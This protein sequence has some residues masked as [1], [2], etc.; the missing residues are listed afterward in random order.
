MSR[1]GRFSSSLHREDANYKMQ[2]VYY[3]ESIR[4]PYF[5]SFILSFSFSHREPNCDSNHVIKQLDFY[6]RTEIQQE[7]AR[8]KFCFEISANTGRLAAWSTE[9]AAVLHRDCPHSRPLVI[10]T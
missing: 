6:F 7:F 3:S 1:L 8:K 5:S 10:R 9:R 4:T 2:I